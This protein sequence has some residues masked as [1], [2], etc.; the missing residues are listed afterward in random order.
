MKD[1]RVDARVAFQYHPTDDMMVTLDNN[2]SRQTINQDNYAFGVWFSQGDLRNVTVDKNGTA[3]DFT[4]AGSP[5]DFTAAENK[6]ILQT[7]Q[8]GLNVK[9]DVTENL[10]LEADG[11]YAKSWLNPGNVIGSKN[12]TSG[13]ATRSATSCAS[14]S[15]ARAAMPSRRSATS[16][17]PAMAHAGPT[18]R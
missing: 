5:T 8:T 11:S 7:N 10:T 14:R 3:V 9:Y 15:T 17:P 16:V 12:G 18:S 13:T 4:Q 1:E 2:F 6:Q